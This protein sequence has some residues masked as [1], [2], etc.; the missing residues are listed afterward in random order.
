M[1]TKG[2]KETH[3]NHVE[4][5]G[6]LAHHAEVKTTPSGRAVTTLS[7]ATKTSFTKDGERQERTEWHRIQAWGKLGEYAAAFQKGSHIR[8]EGELRGREYETDSGQVRTYEI[9]ASSILNL[10]PGRR[11][12]AADADPDQSAAPVPSEGTAP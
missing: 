7:L 10:R 2:E 9:V 1:S 12:T 4:P 3:L 5:I 6:F 11:D 8:V